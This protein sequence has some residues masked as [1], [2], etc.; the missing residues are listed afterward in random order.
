MNDTIHLKKYLKKRS[1]H[2]V[3][4]PHKQIQRN[5]YKFFIVIPCYNEFEYIFDTLE[6]INIQDQNLLNNTLVVIIIN[7]SIDDAIAIKENNSKTYSEL[8]KK[9]YIFDFIAIDCFS[10]KNELPNQLAGVGYARK[11]GLD[12]CLN[13]AL[14]D[15]SIFCSLDADTLVDKNY[16]NIIDCQFNGNNVNAAVINF[17]H[18]KSNNPI[19]EEGIR[20]YELLLKSIAQKIEESNNL[21]I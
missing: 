13:Y 20:K 11:I 18:Q 4:K 17:K 2:K 19:I 5:N 9:E 16:L 15:K 6:S 7:H 3:G 8:I 10:N 14:D 12:F 21:K 1:I